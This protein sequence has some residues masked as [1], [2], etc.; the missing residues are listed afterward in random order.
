MKRLLNW[1]TGLSKVKKGLIILAVV[2]LSGT[3]IWLVTKNK[4]A[5]P[6]Y[7]TA[8]VE[9]GTLVASVSVS[10]QV[11]SANSA[12][13]TTQSSGVVK[14]VSVKDGDTVKAGDTIAQLDL[15]LIG[16]QR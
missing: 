16:R 1:F 3:G 2:F 11:S 6:T 8:Q 9:K 12:E 14:A 5:A 4:T 7:Q 10:G 15:D 13:V